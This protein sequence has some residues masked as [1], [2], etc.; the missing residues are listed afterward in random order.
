MLRILFADI[1]RIQDGKVAILP[2][3]N[4]VP[5]PN[6]LYRYLFFKIPKNRLY[7]AENR[8]WHHDIIKSVKLDFSGNI[9]TEFNDCK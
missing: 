2:N 9:F 1:Q 8:L 6:I 5:S 7:S 4:L 3:F